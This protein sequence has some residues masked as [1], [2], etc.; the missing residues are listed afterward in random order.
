MKWV[1]PI[2]VII[3][4]VLQARLWIGEGS[5]AE[6]AGLLD[7]IDRQ[8][9]HNDELRERN[10]ELELDLQTYK[11]GKDGIEEKARQDMGMIRDGE[12]F[13]LYLPDAGGKHDQ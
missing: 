7:R 2:L 8:Q 12:T 10:R 11:S 6:T 1:W 13:F 9:Q 3:L 4:L 5:L